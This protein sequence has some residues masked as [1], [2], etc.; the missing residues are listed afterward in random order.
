MNRKKSAISSA[1]TTLCLSFSNL[2]S[3]RDAKSGGGGS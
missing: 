3:S 1:T 2:Y